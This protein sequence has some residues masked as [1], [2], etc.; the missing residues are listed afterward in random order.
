MSFELEPPGNGSERDAERG[1]ALLIVLVM[2]V[3]ATTAGL[4]LSVALVVDLRE[5]KDDSRRMRLG[6]LADAAVEEALA[7]LSSN[8]DAGGYESHDYGGG[9]VA[10]TILTLPDGRKQINARATYAGLERTIVAEIVFA[11]EPR[12]LTWAAGKT[13]PVRPLRRS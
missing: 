8:A 10:S 13:K 4:L 9:T 2:L 11:P 7:A 6:A 3:I 5:Q 12:V 1:S